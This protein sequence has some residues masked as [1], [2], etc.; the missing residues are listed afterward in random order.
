MP[1]IKSIREGIICLFSLPF[2]FPAAIL[3]TK[4]TISVPIGTTICQ[5][6][7]R[8]FRSFEF[9]SKSLRATGWSEKL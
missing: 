2:L 3:S 5:Q 6:R 1:V 8:Q 4:E 7:I 9:L